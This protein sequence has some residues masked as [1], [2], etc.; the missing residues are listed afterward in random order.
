MLDLKNALKNEKII[1]ASIDVH[2]L[3]AGKIGKDLQKEENVY[4]TPHI[5]GWTNSFWEKNC[6]VLNFNIKKFKGGKFSEM[7]N[8]IYENGKEAIF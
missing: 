5:A 8:L 2:G 7:K 1:G 3:P 4:L 6:E